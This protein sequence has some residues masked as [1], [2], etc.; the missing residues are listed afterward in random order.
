MAKYSPLPFQENAINELTEQFI[1]LWSNNDFRKMPLVFKSP[2]GSGKTFIVTNFIDNLNDLPN[3]DQD[4]AFIWVTF[5]DNLAIQSKEKFEEYFHNSLRNSL[6]LVNG[7]QNGKLRKNDIIFINWQKLVTHSAENRLLRRPSEKTM[8]KEQGYYWEDFIDN[9][10]KEG[11]ELILIIDEVHKNADTNLAQDIIDY[12][13]PKIILGFSATPEYIPSFPDVKYNRAGYVE[14]PLENVINEGLIKE[15]IVSQSKEDLD[16]YI[17]EDLDK[18]LLKLGLDKRNE[19]KKQFSEL[20]KNINPLLLIQ[21]PNDDHLLIES[22]QRTKED[23]VRHY[24]SEIGVDIN[25]IAFWF[26]NKK[27][28][29]ENITENDNKIDILLFKQA[30]GTGWDCPRAHVLVMYRDISSSTFYIQTVGRIL[31]MPDPQNFGDYKNQSDL[32][33]GFLYTNYARNEVAIP[34]QSNSNKPLIFKSSL[35]NRHRQDI[36]NF[37]LNSA[38]VSRTDYGDLGDSVSFQQSFI[39]SLNNFF[40]ISDKHNAN[41]KKKALENKG[42]NITNPNL[43]NHMIVDLS[44][45]DFDFL[46]ISLANEGSDTEFDMS[47]YDIEKT[48]NFFCFQVLREQS[49]NDTRIT[50]VSRSWS[51]L[52]SALRVWFRSIFGSD[53]LLVYK[54]FISDILKGSSSIFR[55]AI[56]KGLREYRPIL[57]RIIADRI[58]REEQNQSP[59]FRIKDEY[60]FSENFIEIKQENCLFDK[61]Y[62]RNNQGLINESNFIT[63]IESN[64]HKIKWWMKNG[65]NGKDWYSISYFNS[66]EQKQNLFYPD[67]IIKFSNGKI[68]VFDTKDGI[69]LN[70]EGRASALCKTIDNLGKEYMGG[71]IRYSNNLFEYCFDTNYNDIS[72]QNNKWNPF[73]TLFN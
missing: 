70:T 44:I 25:S 36:E 13:N 1:S 30:A 57:E 45:R 10:H 62:L 16:K 35:R 73:I 23:I 8:Q 60:Y 19:L 17:G 38:Y 11:R 32:R 33:T 71:I 9:T 51:P 4:K 22:G 64:S 61:C 42:I 65:D 43:T 46:G 31:R 2:T 5:N 37:Q 49:E 40:N 68:G 12:I 72:P 3:W 56:S 39:N 67:W 34:N 29:L 21:I 47:R 63:Y 54:I 20:S 52:K 28:N 18:I 14:V 59:I 41:D 53:Y 15:K 7:I 69:T 24:L 58:Q 27:I 6:L 26:D 50:S 66:R 55:V 48:F